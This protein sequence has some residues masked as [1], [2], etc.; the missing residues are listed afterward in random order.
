MNRWSAPVV[1]AVATLWL[2]GLA[3]AFAR[4]T[5]DPL[6]KSPILDA[7]LAA[8]CFGLAGIAMICFVLSTARAWRDRDDDDDDDF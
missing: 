2:G 7:M 5:S 6:N 4:A 1:F 3:A 8:S